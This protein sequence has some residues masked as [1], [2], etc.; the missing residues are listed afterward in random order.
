[1]VT[2]CRS[3]RSL[4]S[5]QSLSVDSPLLPSLPVAARVVREA[6][7]DKSYRAFPLGQEA[8]A[9]LRWKRGVITK[10]TYRDYESCLDKLARDFPTLSCLT[11]SR[12]SAPNAWRSS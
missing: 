11:L 8:G 3:S 1:M 9:Y 7:R 2:L 4:T 12:L 6:V 5:W 10:S